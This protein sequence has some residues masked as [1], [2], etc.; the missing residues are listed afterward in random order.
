MHNLC[1]FWFF[2]LKEYFWP[3]IIFLSLRRIWLPGV[4]CILVL[5]SLKKHGKCGFIYYICGKLV[6]NTRSSGGYPG[7]LVV[8]M[9]REGGLIISF[10]EN[11]YQILILLNKFPKTCY[12][13]YF[14]SHRSY[15]IYSGLFYQLWFTEATLYLLLRTGKPI[16]WQT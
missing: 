5:F 7:I 6:S 9:W 10:I 3:K 2:L 15:I 12:Q 8:L 14:A 16:R 4:H 11:W 1:V 13:R